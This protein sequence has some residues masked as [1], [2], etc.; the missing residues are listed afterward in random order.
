[1][2]K[3]RYFAIYKPFG[4]LS[5]FS[6]DGL[7]LAALAGLP[8]GVYPVGRL[9]AQSEGLLVIT[10]DASVNS[11]LLSPSRGHWR[12]YFVQVEG[13]ISAKALEHLAKGVS[14]TIDH[15]P[16]IT[17][18]SKV[19]VIPE[20]KLPERVPPIRFRKSVPDSWISLSLTEGKN[21]QVRKMTAAV[22]FPTLRLV[23]YSIG[24]LTI[25]GFESGEIREYSAHEIKRLLGL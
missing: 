24:E 20:P 13:I 3:F 17:R 6:G 23:R 10:D 25:E 19:H 4:M 2:A 18:P 5:Q 11:A 7:T 9:D 22:G 8:R 15:K 14:I 16:F 21:H 1:M 12:T